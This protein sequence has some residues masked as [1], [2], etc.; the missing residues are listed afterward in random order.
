MKQD[1]ND[2]PL[3]LTKLDQFISLY[4]A[5]KT[6]WENAGKILV[7]LI[8]EDPYAYTYIIERCPM[9]TPGILQAFERIGRGLMLPSLAMDDSPA[10]RMMKRLPLKEQV[11]LEN[12]PIPIIV[13]NPDGEMDTRLLMFKDMTKDQRDQVI[14]RDRLRTEGEMRARLAESINKA[15]IVELA[16]T[17]QQ[18]PWKIRG[19][20]V[21]INGV[22]FSRKELASILAQMD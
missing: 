6:A 19:H 16:A 10:A 7:E 17:K 9:L 5:G 21:I 20:K 1:N 13:V 15:A 22:E 2:M 12:E 8:E 11:R 4:T 14:D 18:M 3:G